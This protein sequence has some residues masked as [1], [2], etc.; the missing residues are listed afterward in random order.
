MAN[1]IYGKKPLLDLIKMNKDKII[2]VHL[3]NNNG[4]LIK[5]LKVNNVPFK[6]HYDKK[7]FDQYG[8]ELNHQFVVTHLKADDNKFNNFDDFLSYDKNTN[9]SIIVILD[10]IQDIRNFGAIL[11]SCYGLG[12]SA[13]IYKANNQAPLN[14]VVI[15][16]SLGAIEHLNVFKVANIANTIDKL[17]ANNYWI[18]ASALN[19]K[20]VN[21]NDVK[22][23]NKT[24]IIV[25]NEDKGVS[26][27][28][29]KKSDF[30]VKIPMNN[31]LQSLNVS[32]ATGILLYEINESI[33]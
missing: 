14:P 23:D 7:F 31:N 26:P 25:G 22:F 19:D 17:K 20:A 3:L 8:M 12:V 29:L 18:Y 13:V 15:K 32:V 9:K 11:R 6:V 21:L 5:M 24:V 1:L 2:L 4:E 16:T 10:E 30:V 28:L 33:K 27:L